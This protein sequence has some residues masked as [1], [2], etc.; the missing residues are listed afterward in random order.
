VQ[1]SNASKQQILASVAADLPA[2]VAQLAG[3]LSTLTRCAMQMGDNDFFQAIDDL[4]LSF[5]QF[6][7]L[8]GLWEHDS[9]LSL[10]AVGDLLGLSL[11]AV[12]RAVDGL[13]V[14]GLVTRVEDS[15]DRRAKRI[16]ATE[17][18]RSLLE[19]V[20]R[21]RAA[22]IVNLAASLD[23]EQRAALSEA[24]DPVVELAEGTVNA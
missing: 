1:S 19:Q 15:A 21:V 2:D 6:K 18:A 23:P 16:S 5:T 10:K 4:Q 9:E 7:I 8:I 22:T 14:R 3:K 13:V 24:L 17:D 11:P 20:V 12:S